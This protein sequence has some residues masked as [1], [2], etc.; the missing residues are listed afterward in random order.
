M[1][2]KCAL[3]R[4]IVD[5]EYK[6]TW[7][8]FIQAGE[9]ADA[10]D[11]RIAS[12]TGL[13]SC[14]RGKG[15]KAF[16]YDP[17]NHLIRFGS[18]WILQDFNWRAPTCIGYCCGRVQSR[19]APIVLLDFDSSRRRRRRQLCPQASSA[20]KWKSNGRRDITASHTVKPSAHTSVHTNT[21]G[22]GVGGKGS[23]PP[24]QNV[25]TFRAGGKISK[26]RLIYTRYRYRYE[27]HAPP[28]TRAQI[29]YRSRHIRSDDSLTARLYLGSSG[30]TGMA[31]CRSL[32][33][34]SNR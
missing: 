25:L 28:A 22:G 2:I 10:V 34:A 31:L 14:I 4:I 1:T 6:V 30:E 16:H 17:I 33:S 11:I 8:A 3:D 24:A 7:L 20:G 18:R 26:R 21:R 29:S 12:C 15:S 27:I 13:D 5:D 19:R 23:T 32:R 9:R